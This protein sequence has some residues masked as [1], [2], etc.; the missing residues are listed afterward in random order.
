MVFN[1]NPHKTKISTPWGFSTLGEVEKLSPS[2]QEAV[3][4]WSN[5][6]AYLESF[7]WQTTSGLEGY[8]VGVMSNVIAYNAKAWLPKELVKAFDWQVDTVF[9]T[10]TIKTLVIA[11]SEDL[12]RDRMRQT[13][14]VHKDDLLGVW[15]DYVLNV[16]LYKP[17][18]RLATP[19]DAIMK[20]VRLQDMMLAEFEAPMFL[21]EDEYTAQLHKVKVGR[22]QRFG[23]KGFCL[24]VVGT[25]NTEIGLHA[26]VSSH[27]Y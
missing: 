27:C 19:L 23:K 17:G 5:S 18:L 16:V 8:F 24:D 21:P 6:A 22:T 3:M 14:I 4:E 9:N 15:I 12:L 11:V 1:L 13:S 7:R 20:R 10:A 26:P 25:P 2:C